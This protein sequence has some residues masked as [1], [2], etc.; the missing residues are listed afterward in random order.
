MHHTTVVVVWRRNDSYDLE[1]VVVELVALLVANDP[2]ARRATRERIARSLRLAGFGAATRDSVAGL[3][4]TALSTALLADLHAG[5]RGA[6]PSSCGC[7]ARQ[8]LVAAIGGRA[9][10]TDVGRIVTTCGHDGEAD[11]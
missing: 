4:G 6:D 3:V 10:A 7:L 8:A 1:R 9:R 2:P 11:Q 5:H